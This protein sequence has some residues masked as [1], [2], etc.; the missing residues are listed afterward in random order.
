MSGVLAE[1][2]GSYDSFVRPAATTR[3]SSAAHHGPAPLPQTRLAAAASRTRDAADQT[4]GSPWTAALQR[5]PVV[6]IVLEL[7]EC[8]TA[9]K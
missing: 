8:E 3:I 9:P 1:A 7:G 6:K 2:H 5:H 4:L